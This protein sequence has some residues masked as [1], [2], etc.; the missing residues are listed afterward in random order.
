MKKIRSD[1]KAFSISIVILFFILLGAVSLSTARLLS[2]QLARREGITLT[3]IDIIA[4]RDAEFHNSENIKKHNVK[5]TLE[6]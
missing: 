5:I 3:D 4:K 6:K 1:S 2:E